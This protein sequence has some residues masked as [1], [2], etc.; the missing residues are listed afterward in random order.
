[1]S[2]AL[3]NAR[4]RR[5]PAQKLIAAC[6]LLLVPLLAVSAIGIAMLYSAGGG[7]FSPWADKQTLRLIGALA[8]MLVAATVPLRIWLGLA[9]PVYLAALLLLVAVM[10]FGNVAMGARRWLQLGPVTLQPSELAKVGIVLVLARY[11]QW[12][13][14]AKV[15]RPQWL[16]LPAALIVL[17]AI[18][19]ARQ[20]DLGSAVLIVAQGLAVMFLAGV[21]VLYFLGAAGLV[22]LAAPHVWER[23]HDYQKNRILTFLDPERDPLG[24]SYHIQQSKIALGSGGLTGKGYM[25]GTQ[26]SMNFLPEKHTD[27]IFTMFGEEMGFVGGVALIGL[28]GVLVLW[29]LVIA[30]RSRSQFGRLVAGGV[31]V[32][33][34]VAVFVNIGM[35][36]GLLPVVGVPLPL[37]SY[38]GTSLLTTLFCLGLVLSVQVHR[39]EGFEPERLRLV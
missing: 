29:V 22:V 9:W 12:L 39:H 33:L 21:S 24:A 18:I 19:V 8:V 1:M 14:A 10:L 35:V 5:T 11:Y 38:G 16:L 28:Y 25:Q 26:S 2:I 30:L 7:S 31:A 34:F 4:E 17:P 13:P 3:D 6:G 23:L 37:M 36:M 20:P 27:F 32:G 15:S